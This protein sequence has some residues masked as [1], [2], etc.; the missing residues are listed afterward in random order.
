MIES[1]CDLNNNH[2]IL[3]CCQKNFFFPPPIS[4][5]TPTVFGRAIKEALNSQVGSLCDVLKEE[6]DWPLQAHSSSF[7]IM[8]ITRTDAQ[9]LAWQMFLNVLSSNSLFIT[10]EFTGRWKWWRE[11]M[12]LTQAAS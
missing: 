10:G 12:M 7:H 11:G 8:T 4:Q 2:H 1:V 3:S 9:P 5:S 6:N